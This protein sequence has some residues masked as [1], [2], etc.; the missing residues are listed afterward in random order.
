MI[1]LC[2]PETIPKMEEW[3]EKRFQDFITEREEM[4]ESM[5]LAVDFSIEAFLHMQVEDDPCIV[6]TG[7]LA[8][9]GLA[10]LITR[11]EKAAYPQD[12]SV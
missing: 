10:Y 2:K 7:L 9:L 4:G 12:K 3:M 6:L 5:K 1:P 11:S 8:K